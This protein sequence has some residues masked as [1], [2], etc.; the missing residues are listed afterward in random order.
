MKFSNFH[1]DETRPLPDEIRQAA[2]Q[3]AD[4]LEQDLDADEW[5]YVLFLIPNDEARREVNRTSAV[6]LSNIDNESIGRVL[7]ALGQLRPQG[8]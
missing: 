2:Q 1:Q 5:A 7:V 4:I 6:C 8:H 3:A